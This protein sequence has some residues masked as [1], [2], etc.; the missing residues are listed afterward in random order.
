MIELS[1]N[2]TYD[3]LKM[4]FTIFIAFGSIY[5]ILQRF[6]L[7]LQT[8][9]LKNIS[10]EIIKINDFCIEFSFKHEQ[11]LI[12]LVDV[13][14]KLILEV[15]IIRSKIKNH[16]EY[17]T[18][19]T[20]AFPFGNPLNFFWYSIF[21]HYL[22]KKTQIETDKYLTC[23]Q[24]SIL[25]DTVLQTEESLEKNDNDVQKIDKERIDKIVLAGLD[26]INFL[27]NHSKK[28]I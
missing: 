8:R 3:F 6:H 5:L 28:L 20:L 21:G 24:D 13:D 22:C 17:L 11:I 26:I 4:L 18:A 16:I 10:D 12:N 15:E 7:R 27:E 14:N 23:Y 19:Q 1:L 9:F 2:A 25:N